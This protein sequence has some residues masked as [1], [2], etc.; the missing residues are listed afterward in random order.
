MVSK[1]DYIREWLG[2]DVWHKKGY[3]GKRGLTLT[4]EPIPGGSHAQATLATFKEIA[5]DREVRYKM[6]TDTPTQAH[7]FIDYVKECGAD[8]MYISLSNQSSTDGDQ[9]E[10]YF[11]ACWPE[12]FSLF[13]SAGN[14]GYAT[15]NKM[16]EREKAYGVGAV[17]LR[18]SVSYGNGKP[19]PGAQ[20]LVMPASYTSVDD[21][22]DFAGIAAIYVSENGQPMNGTSFSGP[23][24]CGMVAL[25]NDFFIDKTGKPLKHEAMYQFLKD[26]CYDVDNNG[27]DKHTGYGVP[28]LPDPDTIDIWKYQD[29]TDTKQEEYMI[30]LSI[31]TTKLIFKKPL[32]RRM[33]T[34]Y[35]IL[36]HAAGTGSIMDLHNKHINTNGCGFSYNY[37]VAKTG[38]IYR[39]R[40]ENAEGYHTEDYDDI[41]IGICFEGDFEKDTMSDGQLYAGQW[42][43]YDILKRYPNLKIR[44]HYDFDDT[45]CPGKNFPMDKILKKI[46][47]KEEQDDIDDIFDEEGLDMTITEFIASLTDAQAYQIIEKAQRHAMRLPL[48]TNWDAKG[49]LKEAVDKGITDGESPMMF[50]PRYQAA[51]MAARAKD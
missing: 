28:R 11:D 45:V 48:P 21:D 17:E 42:L 18:W 29:L 14:D 15:Y 33:E 27:K 46:G 16:I 40:D 7:G 37:Y 22:V 41:S 39:G 6:F 4:G 2:V 44:G 1:N 38:Q 9:V 8:C 35:I 47:Y 12:R 34:K 25:I 49:A 20:M 13:L 19:A 36:H 43:V 23:V 24:L 31:N 26:H 10:D 32:K 30:E 50:I 3:T 5:P 51:I